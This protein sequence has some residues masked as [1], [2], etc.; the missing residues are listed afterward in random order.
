VGGQ[1]ARW[2][3]APVMANQTSAS[4]TVAVPRAD[5]M[6]VIADFAAYPQWISAIRSAD[7]IERSGTG[8]A[9]RVRIRLDAGV[10]KDSFVLAYDWDGDTVVRWDLAEPGSVISVMSGG[11]LLAD[12]DDGTEVT[13]DL[14]VDVRIPMLGMLKR[15]AEKAIIDTALKG[16]KN[17]AEAGGGDRT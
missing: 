13:Y 17:R 1:V 12:T 14:T 5:V 16:L 10:V 8:L 15:R 4:I 6:A 11:Y 3:Y 7:V 9:S 2:R